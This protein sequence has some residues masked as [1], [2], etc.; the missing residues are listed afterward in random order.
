MLFAR[1]GQ[2][3]PV[4]KR[5]RR[6]VEKTRPRRPRRSSSINIFGEDI[7]SLKAISAAAKRVKGVPEG[8][9]KLLEVKHLLD[10]KKRLFRKGKS[11]G[12]EHQGGGSY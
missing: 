8:A 5:F 2:S 1:E 4:Q 6:G 10:N 9:K 7:I 3:F 12:S 11:R